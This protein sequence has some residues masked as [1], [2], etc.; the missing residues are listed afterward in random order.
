MS[1]FTKR[2]KLLSLLQ[3]SNFRSLFKMLGLW[4][5]LTLA[6]IPDG[7]DPV[8]HIRLFGVALWL[9]ISIGFLS[10]SFWNTIFSKYSFPLIGSL[11]LFLICTTITINKATSLPEA[12]LEWVR[13]F[14][15]IGTFL[16]FFI[17][18]MQAKD[19][20]KWEICNTRIITWV[21]FGISISALFHWFYLSLQGTL[22]HES[23]YAITL[24]FANRN[25]LAEIGIL[26]LPLVIY[27]AVSDTHKLQKWISRITILLLVFL[28]LV[29]WCR[30]VWIALVALLPIY[31]FYLMY[32]YNWKKIQSF[33]LWGVGISVVIGGVYLLFADLSIIEKQWDNLI[34]PHYGSSE[35]RITLWKRTWDLIQD[36]PWGIG[37]GQWQFQWAAY[38]GAKTRYETGAVLFTRPHNDALWIWSEIG[39]PGV[40][41]WVLVFIIALIL[42]IRQPWKT[43]SLKQITGLAGII[44]WWI[45][46]CFGFPKERPEELTLLAFYLALCIPDQLIS[47]PLF[48]DLSLYQKIRNYSVKSLLIWILIGCLIF[49]FQRINSERIM[50]QVWEA[51]MQGN[52]PK[53][54][55]LSEQARSWAYDTD[56]T[57]TPV[58]WYTANGMFLTGQTEE[59]CQLYQEARNIHP[60]HVHV[61]NNMGSCA[62]ITGHPE[63]AIQL[64]LQVLKVAPPF[65]EA[66]LN[67]AAVEYNRGN[68]AS[69]FNYLNSCSEETRKSPQ[70][71]GFQERILKRL[72]N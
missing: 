69:A 62:E 22:T 46:S 67:L 39:Y 43:N 60:Y 1:I 47:I 35:E 63:E 24:T 56:P 55:V 52:F 70:W 64:Y 30:S 71:K 18:R 50:R 54:V 45:I 23:S 15:F 49:I 11:V 14:L 29:L 48:K 51:R 65:D 44:I 21:A 26:L 17:E 16:V 36:H 38:S 72:N 61:L 9:L 2:M 32:Q 20:L 12:G 6:Y 8:L 27:N 53:M 57:S 33:M 25:I 42:L 7:L 58:I 31:L 13:Q 34:N 4:A 5:I 37:P 59:A 10:I 28:S 19:T 40:I 66:K 68:P 41:S 3:E